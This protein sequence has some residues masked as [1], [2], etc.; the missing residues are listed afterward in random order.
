MSSAAEQW[1]ERLVAFPSI[2]G[3]PQTALAQSLGPV[4]ESMGAHVDLSPGIRPDATNLLARF[5]DANQKHVLL[6]A[7]ADVV[8]AHAPD[9]SSPP[10]KLTPRGERL[11]GR[12][13]TDMKGFV[14]ATLAAFESFDSL[15]DRPVALA[16]STDE[17]IGVQG[18]WPLLQRIKA[19]MAS[20]RFCVVGEPTEMRVATAHKG[21]LYGTIAIRGID[22]HSSKPG[23]CSAISAAA[24]AI[25][26]LEQRLA[27]DWGDDADD[28]FEVPRASFNVGTI[29]GGTATNVIAGHCK[30]QFEVRVLPGKPVEPVAEWV[31]LIAREAAHP[32]EVEVEI[33]GSYP[34]LN[35]QSDLPA[36][37]ARLAGTSTTDLCVDFG[38]EAGAIQAVLGTPT[39]VC[40]PGDVAQAHTV[41][42]FLKRSELVRATDFV[43]RLIETI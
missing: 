24:R 10:F 35:E 14:A 6:S 23:G 37:V 36:R 20:P 39:V 9:W 4:L 7:H 41:D 29:E 5:G 17:E 43:R 22:G 32:A 38:T 34:G 21:K 28:R 30:F 1:L 13:T 18:V 19:T 2:P 31:D 12:G 40:G 26:K 33:A 25:S 8:P 27:V 15:I 16:L 11:Y 3:S 42:E